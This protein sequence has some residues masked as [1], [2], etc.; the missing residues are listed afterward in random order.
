M[1]QGVLPP[2]T[3]ELP[4][5]P[6]PGKQGSS[7]ELR[8]T[9]SLPA[10]A[11][12]QPQE[13]G[14][15]SRLLNKGPFGRDQSALGTPPSLPLIPRA[16]PSPL[17]LFHHTADNKTAAALRTSIPHCLA[18]VI[19]RDTKGAAAPAAVLAA[20]DGVPKQ[21]SRPGT[22]GPAPGQSTAGDSGPQHRGEQWHLG[23]S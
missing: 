3:P 13:P 4:P 20:G 9:P 18:T 8:E 7:E 10:A 21:A 23:E 6:S 17:L 19:Q 22:T 5:T 12:S 1:G 14:R 2:L 11:S 15:S 16:G